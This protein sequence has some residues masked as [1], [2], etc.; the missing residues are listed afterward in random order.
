MMPE[1]VPYQLTRLYQL[2]AVASPLGTAYQYNYQACSS[3]PN[4][5]LC[6]AVGENTDRCQRTKV[7][8][9]KGRSAASWW[10]RKALRGECS[11]VGTSS[12]RE[13]ECSLLL[14]L[15]RLNRRCQD[16]VR[17][18]GTRTGMANLLQFSSPRPYFLKFSL[19]LVQCDRYYGSR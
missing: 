6:G 4:P 10:Q 14:D 12:R 3:A 13:G 1:V 7:R 19:I 17:V 16:Q 18:A 11:L 15:F 5:G 2:G 8:I 9:P